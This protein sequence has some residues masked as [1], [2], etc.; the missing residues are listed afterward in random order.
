MKMGA[1]IRITEQPVCSAWIDGQLYESTLEKLP[2]YKGAL[3]VLIPSVQV[4]LFSAKL[5]SKQRQRVLQAVPYALEDR[6]AEDVEDLHFAL[7]G[8]EQ[9]QQRVAVIRHTDMQA[10]QRRLQ[11]AGLQASWIV[12][13]IFAV[14]YPEKGWGLLYLGNLALLRTGAQSGFAL[15]TA[16]L[17]HLLPMLLDEQNQ[18]RPKHIQVFISPH[19]KNSEHLSSVD[20]MGVD[21]QEK[22]LEQSSFHLFAETLQNADRQYPPINLR[23]GVYLHTQQWGQWWKAWRLSAILLGFWLATQMLLQIQQ[24]H[25][26]RE[27]HE[28]VKTQIHTLYRTSFPATRKIINPRLQMQQQLDK[29]REAAGSGQ[30]DTG[31]LYLLRH[32][33]APLQNTPNLLLQ[34][35]DYRQ[36]YMDVNLELGS[37]QSLETLK[38]GLLKQA[39]AVEIRSASSR[40]NKVEAQIR[41]KMGMTH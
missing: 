19:L 28:A 29:L 20:V 16:T 37:L 14:P 30:I 36:H 7:G 17:K 22:L 23:Q 11:A 34:R 32:I 12:P 39:L 3:V 41:I 38:Q 15:E 40:N 6:L 18:A 2:S 5:P 25:Q 8:N 24:V 33:S 35:L 13:D 26:L 27:E 1:L 31:V 9:G 4:Q 21:L 10:L